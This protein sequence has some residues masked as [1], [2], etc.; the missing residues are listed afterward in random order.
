MLEN[1]N[2]IAQYWA[3]YSFIIGGFS[4]CFFMLSLSWLCGGKSFS[5]NKHVP[6]ES[7]INSLGDCRL[8]FTVKF[9]LIAMLFVIFDVEALYLYVWTI[10]IYKIGWIGFLEVM[11]FIFSLL[12]GLFYL[13]KGNLFHWSVNHNSENDV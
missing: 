13:V 8:P 11:I 4:I 7:G 10:N 2:F 12:L 3:F 9:Y 1:T 6:F 5:R